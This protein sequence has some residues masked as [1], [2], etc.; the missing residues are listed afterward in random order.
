MKCHAVR[1]WCLV[2]ALAAA[3][4]QAQFD[5]DSDDH[6]DGDDEAVED[7]SGKPDA[8]AAAQRPDADDDRG[9]A[10]RPPGEPEDMR[11]GP[12]ADAAAPRDAGRLRPDAGDASAPPASSDADGGPIVVFSEPAADGT[13]VVTGTYAV[14][15]EMDVS[16]EGRTLAGVYPLVRAGTGKAVVYARADIDGTFAAMFT[17][18]AIC[19]TE[20]PEFVA[21][22][23]TLLTE[24]YGVYI[25]DDVW[26]RDAMP[27]WDAVWERDCDVARPG[28]ALRG[29]ELDATL[30]ATTFVD[31]P[32]M[33][34]PLDH[35]GD[36]HPGVTVRT[37]TP[38]DSAMEYS[39]VPVSFSTNARSESLFSTIVVS[40][41]FNAVLSDCDSLAGELEQPRVAIRAIGC[42]MRQNEGADEAPCSTEQARFVGDNVPTVTAQSGSFRGR[43]IRHGVDC[44]AVRSV[45]AGD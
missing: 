28:C 34:M 23:M 19:G 26:E 16:W 2:A 45:F 3:C 14:R 32:G 18:V 20:F 29:L 12:D 35:D 38:E 39:R 11:R 21:G 6:G 44:A 7:A 10:V 9:A 40:A 22:D 17:R 30:G 37:R 36:G 13:C 24:R 4:T 8:R 41:Q 15:A 27:R 1:S 5:P 43:R 33:I 25:P 42:L 31:P